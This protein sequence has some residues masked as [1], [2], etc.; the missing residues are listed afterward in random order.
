MD[1]KKRDDGTYEL[2]I[3]GYVCPHPLIHFKKSIEQMKS[4]EIV[5][6][7]FDNPGS[8]QTIG[9]LCR[10]DKHQIL[11]KNESEGVITLKIQKA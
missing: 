2:D 1:F 10:K 8:L 11:G 9:M 4:E 7:I 3:K 6:V 5:D